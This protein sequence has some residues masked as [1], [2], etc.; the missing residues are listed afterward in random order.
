M[1]LPEQIGR[2]GDRLGHGDMTGEGAKD[3]PPDC[4][5]IVRRLRYGIKGRL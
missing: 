1:T 4:R 3:P 5:R 2:D